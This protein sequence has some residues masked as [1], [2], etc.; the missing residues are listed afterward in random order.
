MGQLPNGRAVHEAGLLL[1][2]FPFGPD[3]ADMQFAVVRYGKN[4]FGA[5]CIKHTDAK[6]LLC[7]VQCCNVAKRGVRM[8]GDRVGNTC[9]RPDI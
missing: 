2:L 3:V 7:N 8:N 1:D 9:P 6:W 5:M 4:D